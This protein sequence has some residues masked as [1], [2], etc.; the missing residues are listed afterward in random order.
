MR[1]RQGD[2]FLPAEDVEAPARS[3]ML[4][5]PVRYGVG[6]GPLMPATM[7]S[8]LIAIGMLCRSQPSVAGVKGSETEV[9]EV[10]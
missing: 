4:Q 3:V 8:R 5:S 1:R 9:A 10:A 7:L 6:V 2:Q